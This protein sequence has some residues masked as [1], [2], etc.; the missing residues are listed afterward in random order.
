M[1]DDL[2]GLK[3]KGTVVVCHKCG[4]ALH[5]LFPPKAGRVSDLSLY[6]RDFVDETVFNEL[7][8]RFVKL[9]WSRRATTRC[10]GCALT[11]TRH[12]EAMRGE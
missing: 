4:K 9:G 8:A 5:M 1:I 7:A 3:A 11:Y 12:G 10:E 6:S 2:T